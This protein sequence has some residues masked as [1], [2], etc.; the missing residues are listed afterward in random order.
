MKNM[1]MT[2][3]ILDKDLNLSKINADNLVI[4][5]DSDNCLLRISV[6]RNNHFC[7]DRII[8]LK[9]EDGE[10]YEVSL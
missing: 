4:D 8:D 7:F 6:F 2:E 3:R 10:N 5:F 9:Q 1:H